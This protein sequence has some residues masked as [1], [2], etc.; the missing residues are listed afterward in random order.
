MKTAK[1][2]MAA[3][4]CILSTDVANGQTDRYRSI[5][6]RGTTSLFRNV[7]AFDETSSVIDQSQSNV[8]NGSQATSG[9]VV[10]TNSHCGCESGSCGSACSN[11]NGVGCNFFNRLPPIGPISFSLNCSR[12]NADDAGCGECYDNRSFLARCLP[13][14]IRL[15]SNACSTYV[16]LF[17]G[18]TSLEDYDGYVNFGTP[19]TRQISFKD[20]YNVGAAIGRRWP[21]NFRTE[22]E[23]VYRRN[24]ADLYS[25]G[26]F[27]GSDFVPTATFDAVN[28]ISSFALMNNL[29]YDFRFSGNRTIPYVGVG[30][31]FI[32]AD[33]DIITPDLNRTDSVNSDVRWSYQLIGGVSRQIN[34]RLQGYV[35]YRYQGTSG[36]RVRDAS[37]PDVDIGR[38][39]LQTSNVL[40]GVRWNLR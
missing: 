22:S 39:A 3:C 35:E 9:G 36:V 6:S 8:V 24:S 37:M 11:G 13:F 29:L 28:Q 30:L 31:G 40:F 34:C 23:M 15:R 33:G 27:V 18:W 10:A 7:S 1:L 19:M 12:S 21:N 4:V 25:E 38:F 17:G 5:S 32:W 2:L 14:R 20:G 26:S 16:S